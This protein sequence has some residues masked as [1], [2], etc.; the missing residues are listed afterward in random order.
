MDP[1]V[2]LDEM[3]EALKTAGTTA[4]NG[5]WIEAAERAMD[6]AAALDDWLSKGGFP[7]QDWHWSHE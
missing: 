1:N 7:P 6:R 5:E 3:R 2:A 4:D